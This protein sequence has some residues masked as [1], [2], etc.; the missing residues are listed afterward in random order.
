M[1]YS[2]D[3]SYISDYNNDC[4]ADWDDDFDSSVDCDDYNDDIDYDPDDDFADWPVTEDELLYLIEGEDFE[5][6][7]DNYHGFQNP[8]FGDDFTDSDTP[9]GEDEGIDILLKEMGF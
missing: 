3:D 7:A 4:G 6:D 5:E 2:N 8:V 9:P 1:P